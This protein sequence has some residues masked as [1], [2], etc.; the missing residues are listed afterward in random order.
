MNTT[1]AINLDEINIHTVDF[2]LPFT[3]PLAKIIHEFINRT[4]DFT[5]R[6]V[7]PQRYVGE[8]INLQPKQQGGRLVYRN[9]TTTESSRVALKF[10]D[11]TVIKLEFFST[12]ILSDA[13]TPKQSRLG[14]TIHPSQ[15]T[16]LFVDN[17]LL[18]HCLLPFAEPPASR[19][20]HL[21]GRQNFSEND[22][23]TTATD[24][25]SIFVSVFTMLMKRHL[26]D[27]MQD[28]V[29]AFIIAW[30]NARVLIQHKLTPPSEKHVESFMKTVFA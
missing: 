24:D 1:P 20:T 8:T 15:D 17:N 5:E 18:K 16:R 28:L 14:I 7:L 25:V 13:D 19:T 23:Q 6:H 12:P 22:G 9:S 29:P 3:P 21:I 4:Q 11:G 2:L 27:P 30:N 26:A 10:V